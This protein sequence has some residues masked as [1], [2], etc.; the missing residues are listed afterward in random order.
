ME[1]VDGDGKVGL[2]SS[3]C[4]LVRAGA[5]FVFGFNGHLL[6]WV[7]ADAIVARCHGGPWASNRDAAPWLMAGSASVLGPW[8]PLARPAQEHKGPASAAPSVPHH[9][10]F[11]FAPTHPLHF[12]VALRRLGGAVGSFAAAPGQAQEKEYEDLVEERKDGD[13]GRRWKSWAWLVCLL[14]CP[15]RRLFCIWLQWALVGLG[16]RRRDSC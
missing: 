14:A 5:C 4:L 10:R 12:S 9:T 2:G 15:R 16:F 11:S 13:G 7:F 6:A 8:G 1:M 3:V